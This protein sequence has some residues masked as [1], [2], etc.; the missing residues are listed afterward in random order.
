MPNIG[1][2]IISVEQ[3]KFHQYHIYYNNIYIKFIQA[4]LCLNY[5][6]S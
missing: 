5:S 3:N 6:K 4:E 1:R 2:Y